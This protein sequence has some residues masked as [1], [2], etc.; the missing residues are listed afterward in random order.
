[1]L[2]KQA[3]GGLIE[4]KMRLGFYYI[5]KHNFLKA[6]PEARDKVFTIQNA[7]SGFRGTRIVPY[8][9]KEVIKQFNYLISTPTPPPP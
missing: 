8:N 2:L 7:Q 3:Y 9:P 4:A 6:Y 5:N 1:V